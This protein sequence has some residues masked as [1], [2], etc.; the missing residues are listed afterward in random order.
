MP[1]IVG[2][3]GGIGSGKS[4]A[5]QWFEHQDIDVVDADVFAREVVQPGQPALE[6]IAQHFGDWVLQADG[7]LDR[8]ALRDYI[9]QHPEAR[10]QLEA[11]T[12]PIIRQSILSQLQQAQSAYVILVSPLLFETG[13]DRM[14]HRNLLVDVSEATQL[15]R[16]SQRDAQSTEQ[17]QKIIATQMPRSEKLKRA[18]DVVHNEGTLD[19][20]YQQLMRLHTDYLTRSPD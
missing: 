8:R 5:S 11:I 18:D 19:E 15:K 7:Q 13:Q 1:Y 14:T 10:Q 6:K 12:H 9:F 17:I 3:T 4:A 20:L 16:A 2:L